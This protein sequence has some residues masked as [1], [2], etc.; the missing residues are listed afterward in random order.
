MVMVISLSGI[1]FEV[2]TKKPGASGLADIMPQKPLEFQTFTSNGPETVW[3][4]MG[5]PRDEGGGAGTM[6]A[7]R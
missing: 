1:E 7:E 6:N 2:Q 4:P 3:R 5:K